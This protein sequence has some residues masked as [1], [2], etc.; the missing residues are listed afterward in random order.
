MTATGR[1]AAARESSGKEALN[2][3]TLV[4]S[5]VRHHLRNIEMQL[6]CTAS[7]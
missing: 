2:R 6:R 7:A 5:S 1:I 3:P 4:A